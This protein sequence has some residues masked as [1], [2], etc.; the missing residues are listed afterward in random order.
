MRRIALL[1]IVLIL[2]TLLAGCAGGEE[3][4]NAPP[5]ISG[6]SV[7]KWFES[8]AKITWV[9]NEPATSQVEYGVS[10]SYGL[11][12]SS[13]SDLTTSHMVFLTRLDPD[14][15][16]HFRVKSKDR[17]SNEAMSGDH[18]FTIL[19]PTPDTTAPLI[20]DVNVTDIAETTA[21]ITWTT[22]E[23]AT[24]Q[25]EYGITSAYGLSS[26]LSSSLLTSHSVNLSELSSGTTYHY[27]V[28]SKDVAGNE[29]KTGDYVFATETTIPAHF[30]TYTDEMNLFSISY[31][32][33]W[34][35][36]LS[37][38]PDLEEAVREIIASIEAD[39]P[40]EQV[41]AIFLAG[42]PSETGYSPNVNILCESFPIGGLTHDQMVEL[43]IRGI[44]D[45]CY[46]YDE[47]ARV[48]TSVGGRVATIV[49]HETTCP[50]WGTQHQLQ[51]C[52]L[53]GKIVWIVTCTPPSG[54]FSQYQDDFHEIVRSLRILK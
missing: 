54:E 22:D 18:T 10:E 9:T 53:L 39:A 36:A 15:T 42:V 46:D 2:G 7:S 41:R 32:S 30:V 40:I 52:I 50:A 38:I 43:E 49:E 26:P 31:P 34:E 4:D 28:K 51:M 37:L 27:R 25:V 11:T 33:D 48:K 8:G 6:I 45:F 3:V 29:A 44:K 20:S 5:V 17:S 35:L 12:S 16:Y 13:V 19:G 21:A 14:T 23:P 24:T 47:Y 1:T